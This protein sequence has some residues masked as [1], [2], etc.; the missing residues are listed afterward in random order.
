MTKCQTRLDCQTLNDKICDSDT[1]KC[2]TL[3]ECQTLENTCD[4]NTS[5]CQTTSLCHT[6][7]IESH[8]GYEIN[9][10]V[11]FSNSDASDIENSLSCTRYHQLSTVFIRL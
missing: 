2:Q 6:S 1:L 11:L 7:D 9:N 5:V 8:M 10:R 3:L 4:N